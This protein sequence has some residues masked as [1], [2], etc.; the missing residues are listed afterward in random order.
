MARAEM[1][2]IV[3]ELTHVVLGLFRARGAAIAERIAALGGDPFEV[4]EVFVLTLRTL[5]DGLEEP[6]LDWL[7][8]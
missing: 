8:G 7:D 4:I 1:S 5:A 2:R 6:S 3:G